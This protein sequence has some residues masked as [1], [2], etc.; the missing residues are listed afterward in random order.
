LT[1]SKHGDPKG[2]PGVK[3][4]TTA[5]VHVASILPRQQTLGPSPGVFWG[6][7]EAGFGVYVLRAMPHAPLRRLVSAATSHSW[8]QST[9]V[10]FRSVSDSRTTSSPSTPP[11]VHLLR[12]RTTLRR[13]AYQGHCDFQHAPL[14][15]EVPTLSCSAAVRSA[16]PGALVLDSIAAPAYPQSTV[17]RRHFCVFD[18][19]EAVLIAPPRS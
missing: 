15:G 17:T 4:R 9:A 5:L 7:F 6:R 18:T 16:T 12:T 1:P 11:R 10:V 14:P 19:P 3:V 8:D 13:P 2:S